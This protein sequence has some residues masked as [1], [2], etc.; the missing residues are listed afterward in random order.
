MIDIIE[1][2]PRDGLQNE[3]VLLSTADKVELIGSA[4]PPAPGGSRRSPS[5]TRSACPS[6]ADAEA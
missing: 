3:S 6:M 5:S 2:S 4:G 1:V